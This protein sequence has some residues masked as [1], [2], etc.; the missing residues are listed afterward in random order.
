MW[1]YG[2]GYDW[3]FPFFPL[4]WLLFWVF[5]I[6]MI[7]SRRRRWDKHFQNSQKDMTAEEVLADRFA[8]G[9]IDEKEYEN[10]LEV[11]KRHNKK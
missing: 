5:V 8:H 9:D 4:L 6:F 1:N 11:L 2:Y 7:F 10:R 3:G